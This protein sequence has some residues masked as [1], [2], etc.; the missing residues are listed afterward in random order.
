MAEI[1]MVRG[2]IT[3]YKRTDPAKATDMVR[4]TSVSVLLIPNP[5]ISG[6]GNCILTRQP[7]TSLLMEFGRDSN[8]LN[9]GL[10]RRLI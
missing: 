8:M 10:S 3:N 2:C 4:K 6:D 5:I 1:K 9:W 7:A